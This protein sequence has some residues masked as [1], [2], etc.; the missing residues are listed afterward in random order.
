MMTVNLFI[1]ILNKKN[2]YTA[3]KRKDITW[4]KCSSTGCSATKQRNKT[5]FTKTVQISIKIT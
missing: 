3:K 1:K 4:M 5:L 2:F